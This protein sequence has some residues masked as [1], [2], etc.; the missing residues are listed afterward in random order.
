MRW[1]RWRQSAARRERPPGAEADSGNALGQPAWFWWTSS[2]ELFTYLDAGGQERHDDLSARAETFV[3]LLLTARTVPS[4]AGCRRD[5]NAHRLLGQCTRFLDLP[6]AINV[7]EYLTPRW[8]AMKI[9][10]GIVGPARAFRG[11][12]EPRG[13]TSSSTRWAPIR[14]NCFAAACR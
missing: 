11:D 7:R 6:D 2:E 10:L 1:C 9:E 3:G 13:H 5:D 4:A 8:A 12:V 14:T